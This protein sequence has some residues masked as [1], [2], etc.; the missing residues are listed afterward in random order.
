MSVMLNQGSKPKTQGCFELS[1]WEERTLGKI[2]YRK[3]LFITTYHWNVNY[4]NERIGR[5]LRKIS[6]LPTMSPW[7]FEVDGGGW[8]ALWTN[9]VKLFKSVALTRNNL[10]APVKNWVNA[11]KIHLN[12]WQMVGL[13]KEVRKAF[14]KIEYKR[15]TRRRWI[16]NY[17]EILAISSHLQYVPWRHVQ[18]KN[19]C[20]P[21]YTLAT[22]DH[23]R[24]ANQKYQI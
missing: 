14:S 18:Y 1:I 20:E 23:K 2:S 10:P 3:T 16:E 6:V 7:N 21:E 22:A 4:Q 15:N 17:I 9:R 5:F 19:I 11:K 8:E 13:W 12:W 24:R